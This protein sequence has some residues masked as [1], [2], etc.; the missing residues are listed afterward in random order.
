[1]KILIVAA[2]QP[3]IAPFLAQNHN[4]AIS[5]LITGVGI[6]ATTFALTRH[7]LTHTYDLV[8]QVG[9]GGSFDT[10]IPLGSLHLITSDRFADLGAEDHDQYLDIFDLGLLSP[11]EAPYVDG[12]L[13]T[14]ILPLHQ[15]IGLP[16]ATGVTVNTVSGSAATIASRSRYAC[17]VESMEGA[18]LHYVCLQL[19]VPFAQVRSISNYVTPRNKSLWKMKDAIINLNNWLIAFV[20]AI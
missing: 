13:L 19:A 2:T 18:A 15:S 4:L 7:L 1:M 12:A 17:T 10:N 11:H 6:T 5:V 16:T 8:L 3:E 20:A 14:P 9:V